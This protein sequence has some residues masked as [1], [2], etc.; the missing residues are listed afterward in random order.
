M[1]VYCKVMRNIYLNTVCGKHRRV[2]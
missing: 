1:A 2:L